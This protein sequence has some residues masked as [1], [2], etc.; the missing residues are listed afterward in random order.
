MVV[1]DHQVVRDGLRALLETTD[2]LRVVAE[3]TTVAEALAGVVA[4]S[5]DV[6]AMDVR[7]PDGSGVEACRD[8]RSAMPSTAVLMLTAHSDEQAVHDSILAGASGYVLKEVRSPE[9]VTS[10]RR[11]AGGE[12]LLDPEETKRMIH[13]LTQPAAESD[14]GL[15]RLTPTEIQMIGLIAEGSTNRQISERLGLA[16]KTAKNYVSNILSKLGATSRAQAAAHFADR[17]AREA[18]PRG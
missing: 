16:E 11:V 8:I 13:Q 4:T 1:D 7:L 14:P 10:L 18:S 3:A 15:A 6:V 9:L 12:S 2:D 5:P 17:R